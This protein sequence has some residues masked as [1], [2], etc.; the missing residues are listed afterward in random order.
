MVVLYFRSG[1]RMESAYGL[2]ITVTM[3]MTTLLLAV[4]L[5][6][7]R[8]KPA[9][10]LFVLVV[11]GAIESVFFFSSL[12]KFAHGGYVAVIMAMLLFAVM[13]IWHK[14]TELEQKYSVRLKLRDYLDNIAALRNDETT[15]PCADN[16]VYIDKGEDPETVDRDILY[17]ILDRDPKRACAYWFFSIHFMDE[18]DVVR[19]KLETFGTDYI[20]RVR[21]ELGFK[22]DQFLNAYLRQIVGD[23]LAS[24]ELPPQQRRFSIYGPSNVGT[25]KFGFIRRSVASGTELTRFEEFILTAKYRI[26]EL[27]GSQIHWYG[28]NTSSLIVESVPL[29]APR[30]QGRTR[31]PVRVK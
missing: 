14:G 2:A 18:P 8:K 16:L 17:S 1:T 25:F 24:G 13:V 4:Y 22:N 6:K 12:A 9:T 3:L 5:M 27:I 29:S 31:K 21:L 10:A 26:R 19:Y 7:V 23:L 11:F 28:L 15:P 20:F 30:R